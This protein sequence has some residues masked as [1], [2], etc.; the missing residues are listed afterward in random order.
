MNVATE[1][2]LPRF[3]DGRTGSAIATN[4]IAIIKMLKLDKL[5]PK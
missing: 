5:E 3:F 4:P 1:K 2:T